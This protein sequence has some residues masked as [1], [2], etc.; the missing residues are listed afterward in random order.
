[1]QE[2]VERL[3]ITSAIA[4]KENGISI[5]FSREQLSEALRDEIVP[6]VSVRSR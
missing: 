1:M 2:M 5:T 4:Y 3:G 6:I